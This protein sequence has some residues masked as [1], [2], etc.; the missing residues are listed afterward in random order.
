[1]LIRQRGSSQKTETENQANPK[2]RW[3]IVTSM[4]HIHNNDHDTP[5]SDTETEQWVIGCI[6]LSPAE[7]DN[8]DDLIGPDDFWDVRYRQIFT[9]AQKMSAAGIPIEIGLLNKSL[10]GDGW[11]DIMADCASSIAAASH[12][13]HYAEIVRDVAAKRRLWVAGREMAAQASGDRPAAEILDDAEQSLAGILSG[14]GDNN[15]TPI[16]D[17]AVEAISEIDAITTRGYG[18]GVMTGLLNFDVDQGGLFPSE[19]TILAARPGIGKTSLAMQWAYHVAGKG[20]LVYYASLEMSAVEL[21]KRLACSISG[22]SSRLVRTARLM[23]EHT[24]K[25]N[26]AMTEI[27]GATMD[28]HDKPAMTVSDIRRQIRGRK[29]HGLK[30][31]VIDYLQL[32]NADD[33]KIPREQ[34]VARMTKTLKEIAREYAVPILCLC[35]LN[36][37]ADGEEEPKLSHLRESGSIEQN[38]DMVL[39]LAPHKP[40]DMQPNNASLVIAKNRNGETGSIPLDWHASQTMFTCTQPAVE[41]WN[42]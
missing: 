17:A 15:P 1:M 36:R 38:G 40:T 22:V 24:R 35:Q 20:D 6:L 5:P 16:R 3:S 33:T 41:E 34:Q 30:L 8:V 4:L 25:L 14:Q 2:R 9:G 26:D 7:L 42:P 28:I 11:L 19:L 12:A 13:R 37:M 29:K 23:P 32:L 31:A 27:A 21:T 39:F 10:A 18:C